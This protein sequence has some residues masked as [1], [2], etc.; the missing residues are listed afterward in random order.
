MV[1]KILVKLRLNKALLVLLALFIVLANFAFISQVF[2]GN[3]TTASVLELGGTSFAN[4]MIV[5]DGQQLAIDFT[6]ANAISSGYYVVL[7]FSTGSTFISAGGTVGA[8]GSQTV[9]NTGCTGLFST[10]TGLPG[11]L[12]VTSVPASGTITIASTGASDSLSASTNYCTELNFA[13]AVTNPGTAASYNVSITTENSG[14]SAIDSKATSINV[15]SAGANQYSVTVAV[16]PTFTMSLSPST[17]S[18]T[19][20]LSSTTVSVTTGVTTTITT[21]SLSG[22]FVWAKD[23]NA[24]LTSTI[25][26][27]TISSV[28]WQSSPYTFTSLEGANHYGLGVSPGT[29]A[30]NTTAYA[31]GGGTTGNG[32][33]SSYNEIAYY[34]AYASSSSTFTTHELATVSGTTPSAPDYTDTIYEIGA[35]SF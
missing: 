10:A 2:A 19:T 20:N 28:T 29:N 14:Q 23:L 1:K 4:P 27:T 9:S 8:S 31:Y 21:N 15:L 25:A 35:G 18:F 32:L 13:S 17:D 5:S 7:N 30:S 24:G 33:S 11:T 3:L 26:S 6:T 22:W 34:S 16:A 12:A